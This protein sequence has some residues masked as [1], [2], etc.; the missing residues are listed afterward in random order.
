VTA[1]RSRSLPRWLKVFLPLM[2]A[3][4]CGSPAPQQRL[5]SVWAMGREG[6]VIAQLLPQFR[7]LH[8]DIEVKIQQL[9]W[10]AAHQKLLTA[11]AG[12]ATPDL[13]QLGN[14][15]IPEFVALQALE[16]L[17]QSLARSTIVQAS[18][19]F[20]G[21]WDTNI[22]GGTLYGVPW[23][24]DTRLL[25]YRRDL[26]AEAGFA[27]PPSSWDEW[28]RMLA[29]IKARVGPERYSVL[30]P[31]DE[32]APLLVLAIQQPEPL[33]REDGRYGNFRSAGFRRA[34]AFYREAFRRQWAPPITGTQIS[35]VW[36]E[37]GRGYYS[38]YI[39]GPWNIGE[40]K[41]RLP[42]EQQ[43]TWMTA[44]M[45]GPDG[46][47]ASLAGGSSL[48]IFRRSRHKEDAWLLLEFLSSPEIQ[49][50]FYQLTGDLPPRRS[51][52]RAP[53]LASNVYAHAFREQLERVKP[54]PKV[55]EWERIVSDMRLMAERVVHGDLSVEEGAADLDRDVDAVL[56]K[57]RWLLSRGI[58]P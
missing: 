47:G 2:C 46:P 30:L 32:F 21:I 22:I 4:G 3:V 12:E 8:P 31:L 37:L 9:P 35:N 15:W 52:W 54:T 18:D 16:P 49:Q 40:F 7:T 5:V 34:L 57:R 19:Y 20:P 45:P 38:F 10:T 48:V 14:T 43:G 25:F 11:F 1:G 6:E 55:P 29:A 44:P 27:D 28:S 50:R 23:Y 41:R 13:C 33:L 24:I 17:S 36:D 56:Q 58:T 51:T 42:P 39:S 53:Q 26:L